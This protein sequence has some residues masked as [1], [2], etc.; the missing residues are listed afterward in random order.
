MPEGPE[1][2]AALADLQKKYPF[3]ASRAILRKS[4]DNSVGLTLNDTAGH[5]RLKVTVAADGSPSIQ[6]LDAFGKVVRTL[7]ADS[8]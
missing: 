3:A 2:K 5:P 7:G 8:K 1:R 6:L 4:S